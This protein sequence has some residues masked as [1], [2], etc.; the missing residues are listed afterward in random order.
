VL[1]ALDPLPVL[2]S[3]VGS[4]KNAPAAARLCHGVDASAVI[5]L[6]IV[7][8][9]R[10]MGKH[11]RVPRGKL[12][13]LCRSGKMPILIHSTSIPHPADDSA[14]GEA[15]G[16]SSLRGPGHERRNR[17]WRGIGG[18]QLRTEPAGLPGI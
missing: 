7:Y 9:L 12:S 13:R 2:A 16:R 5:V 11:S 10:I 4:A 6:S 15:P 17:T 14:C 1:S 3:D 18:A 8:G